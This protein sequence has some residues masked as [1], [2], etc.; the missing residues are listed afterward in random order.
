MGAN[1]LS[2]GIG[3]GNIMP[4]AKVDEEFVEIAS[5]YI[6]V[7]SGNS[8]LAKSPNLLQKTEVSGSDYYQ[9]FSQL[10]IAMAKTEQK[11]E[12]IV[13][14]ML[15]GGSARGWERAKQDFVKRFNSS[16]SP[17]EKQFVTG[18]GVKMLMSGDRLQSKAAPTGK[19]KAK[20]TTTRVLPA[21]E[22]ASVP[23]GQYQ[24]QGPE[25]EA[26]AEEGPGIFGLIG[27]FF[28]GGG[29]EAT[30]AEPA[31]QQDPRAYEVIE[32]PPIRPRLTVAQPL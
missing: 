12:E 13:G 17:E 24:S 31:E 9:K 15:R 11:A 29:G 26:P 1:Y 20:S 22:Q 23:T 3:F 19:A 7:V 5:C 2:E 18:S 4:P 30:A 16:L 8:S 10:Q 27:N 25:E 21:L 14:E 6:H 28:F 32:D